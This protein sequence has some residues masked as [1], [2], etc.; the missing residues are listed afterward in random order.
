MRAKLLLYFGFI[1]SSIVRTDGKR[2]VLLIVGAEQKNNEICTTPII[3]L[4]TLIFNLADDGGFQMG[5]YNSMCITENLD[6]L[7][8]KSLIFDNAFT[9]VSSCS[10]R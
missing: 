6:N 9:A 5:S 2:N 8:K 7:A 1:I 3:N 10:P 4:M